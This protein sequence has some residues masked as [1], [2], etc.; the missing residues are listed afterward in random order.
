VRKQ[1]AVCLKDLLQDAGIGSLP[2]VETAWLS[3][4]LHQVVDNE[5]SVAQ[6]ATKFVTEHIVSGLLKPR[7]NR[8]WDLMTIVENDPEYK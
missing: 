7:P 6:Q 5:Q 1:A 3:G 8:A 2:M 4:L